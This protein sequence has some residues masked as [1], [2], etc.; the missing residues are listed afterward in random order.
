MTTRLVAT[1]MPPSAKAVAALLRDPPEGVDYV[2]LRLDALEQPSPAEVD[3]LLALP[4]TVP[5]VVTCRAAAQGGL[6]QGE[7]ADRLALLAHAAQGGADLVDIEDNCLS[8]LPA[9]LPGERIASCHLTRFVPRLEALARRLVAHD[10]AFAKLAVPADAPRQLAELLE[11]QE[12]HA[13][14]LAIVPTGRLAEAGR[15]MAAARG[16]PLTYGAVDVAEPGHP[17][18][19]DVHRLHEVHNANSLP[20]GTRFFGV[21]GRPVAHSMSPAYHNT[22]FRSIAQSARMLPLDVDTLEELLGVADALRLDGLAVTHPFKQDAV[23]MAHSAMPGARGTGAANTLLRTPAGWQ[24]RNTDWKAA[25]DLLPRLLDGWLKGHR[26]DAPAASWLEKTLS[27]AQH[28]RVTRDEGDPVPRVV[29]LGSGGA[30]RA[31]AVA[32]YD[33]EVELVI[34]SRRLSHARTLAD[35]LAG[36]LPAVAVPDPGH[37][38]GDLV[39]NATPVG[40]PGVDQGELEGLSA[41]TFRPGAVALDLTYGDGP[42]AFRDAA[43]AAGVPVV[44]GETF[45]GLQARRQAEA[46]TGGTLAADLRRR[47][48]AACGAAG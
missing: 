43:E 28:K 5:L 10:V 24:A 26:E 27:R 30:A 11:L 37:S 9:N 40:L 4:R 31:L 13:D 21:V 46:F 29:L 39:I 42:S 34:W 32:L 17:D 19:P 41:A 3:A 33:E 1:T 20:A 12:E 7:E 36:A 45:F 8:E 14:R 2:E 15:V 23:R 6:W 44:S 22:V 18:Q 38:P 25:C 48:A 35:E 47:A 16:S